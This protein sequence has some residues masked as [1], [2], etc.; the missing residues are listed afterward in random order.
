MKAYLI[1][2]VI[3]KD[4]G[5]Y[6]EYITKAQSIVESFGGRYLVRGGE[7]TPLSDIWKPERIVMIEF[8]DKESVKKCFASERY[9]RIRYLREESTES[10]AVI[11]EGNV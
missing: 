8:G 5:K 2:D 10:K 9:Q 6:F 4:Q 1:I 11:V 7:I 3:I